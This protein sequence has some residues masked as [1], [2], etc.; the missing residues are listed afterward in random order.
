M[1]VDTLVLCVLPV[2]VGACV[3]GDLN[4]EF[5]ILGRFNVWV[6]FFAGFVYHMSMPRPGGANKH[7]NTASNELGILIKKHA[8]TMCVEPVLLWVLI[9]ITLTVIV[10]FVSDTVVQ[11]LPTGGGILDGKSAAAA[12]G[13]T[14]AFADLRVQ[15]SGVGDGIQL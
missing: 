3:V 11:S 9:W 1:Q 7:W 13:K 8:K 5:V 14:R 15:G 4:M 2:C 6:F 10:F 12:A